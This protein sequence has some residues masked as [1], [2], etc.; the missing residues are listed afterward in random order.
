MTFVTQQMFEFTGLAAYNNKV[1][2]YINLKLK[3]Y[4]GMK[5]KE[6]QLILYYKGPSTEMFV[7]FCFCRSSF[8]MLALEFTII[9]GKLCK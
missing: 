6:N 8:I 7:S 3:K 9:S 4:L 5:L 2:D 1:I